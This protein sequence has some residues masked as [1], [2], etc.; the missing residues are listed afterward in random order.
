MQGG[1]QRRW[2]FEVRFP[3]RISIHNELLAVFRPKSLA[4]LDWVMRQS[5]EWRAT[6]VEVLPPYDSPDG[7]D[8]GQLLKENIEYLVRRL[9]C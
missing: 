2:T 8:S 1:D 9:G 5:A 6:G 7:F 3:N 4:G